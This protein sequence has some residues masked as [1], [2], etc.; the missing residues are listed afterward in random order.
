MRRDARM[1]C[2]VMDLRCPKP[3][4]LY[5]PRDPR[6]ADLWR[7]MDQHFET[8]RQVY[9]ERYQD[10]YG[11]W[12]PVVDRSVTAFLKCGDLEEGFARVRCPDCHHEMFVAYSC[13]QR[14]TCPSCHQKRTLLTALHVAEEVCAP[15]AHRQVVLTISKRLRRHTRF[16]RRLLGKL[17][18]CVWTCIQAEVRRLLGRDDVSPG[19]VSAIQTHGEL[20]HW[21]PHLHAVLTCG[22]FTPAG[23]FLELPELDLDRLEVAWQEAVFAL[24]LAE[25]RIEPEVVENMRTWEHSGFSV[26]QSVLLRADD[27][28]GIERLVQYI[29]RCPFSLARLV[30]VTGNESGGLPGGEGIEPLLP[31]PWW[32]R[33]TSGPQ[34]E[35]SDPLPAGFPGGIHA[36]Y[37][38]QGSASDPL[39]RLVFQQEPGDAE[40]GGRGSNGRVIPC[41]RCQ[42]RGIKPLQSELGDADQAGLR[43]GPI[44]VSGMW[45]PDGGGGLYRTAPGGRD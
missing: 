15:V 17:S 42:Q 38:R 2:L 8:F 27:E 10:K 37:S 3:L 35:L 29:T 32:R 14:C 43:G 25:D 33:H 7:L 30:K 13:K 44:I 18:H 41:G 21:H 11:F 9:A 24:Y 39:L 34:A 36:A 16:D 23:D 22:A 19:M 45:G 28:A 5:R 40:G 26:D 12:R 6:A 4:P 20:L 1:C 31:R